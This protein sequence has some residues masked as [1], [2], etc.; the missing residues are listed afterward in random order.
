MPDTISILRG[1]KER[2]ET[3]HGVHITDRALVVAAE[4]SSRYIQGRFLPDK[5]RKIVHQGG[6]V[7]RAVKVEVGEGNW[8]CTLRIVR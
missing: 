4:L 6:G 7:C 8:T 2:Y 5:V 3:H 1:L